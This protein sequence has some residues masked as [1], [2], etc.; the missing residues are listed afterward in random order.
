MPKAR[1]PTHLRYLIVLLCK[2][3]HCGNTAITEKSGGCK[4]EARDRER[5]VTYKPR[6]R[7]LGLLK[8]NR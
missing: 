6:K 2:P 4:D 1:K 3:P 8:R 5:T 7:E